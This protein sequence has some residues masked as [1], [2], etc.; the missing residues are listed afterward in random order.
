V[1]HVPDLVH[2]THVLPHTLV[3]LHEVLLEIHNVFVR[4]LLRT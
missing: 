1:V 3:V 4:R 2:E